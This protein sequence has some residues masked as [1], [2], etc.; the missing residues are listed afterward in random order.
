MSARILIVDDNALNLELA[1]DVLEMEGFEVR[2]AASG[3]EGIALA[4]QWRPDLVLM[5]LRMPEMSGLDALQVLRER[6]A[7]RDIPVAVLTAS[8]M[9][10]DEE[11]LLNS[12]FTA[13]LS[14]PI[15]PATFGARVAEL[16]ETTRQGEA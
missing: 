11:R 10:G 16:L 5:D 15:D 14:K 4:E 9:K 3:A 13:Y 8:A 7:T 1:A 2:T 12:G 6:E